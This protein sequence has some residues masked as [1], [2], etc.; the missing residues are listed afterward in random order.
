MK[1]SK[2]FFALILTLAFAFGLTM[3]VFSANADKN[4]PLAHILPDLELIGMNIPTPATLSNGTG[5]DVT[6]EPPSNAA[7]EE[8]TRAMADVSTYAALSSAI[9][10][11]TVATIRVMNDIVMTDCLEIT[12]DIS[13]VSGV[14]GAVTL[15]AASAKRH[16]EIEEQSDVDIVFSN[17]VLDG[18]NAG[19]GMDIVNSYVTISG[20]Y[21]TNCSWTM[22]GAI[23]AMNQHVVVYENNSHEIV[24]SGLVTIN[25]STFENNNSSLGGAIANLGIMRVYNSTLSENYAEESGGAIYA[26]NLSNGSPVVTISNTTIG[27]NE[28]DYYGGGIFALGSTLN[29]SGSEI[30]YNVSSAGGGIYSL[31]CTATITDSNIASNIISST[32]TA[33]T[34][35]ERGGAGIWASGR[36]VLYNTYVESNEANM[37]VG[38]GAGVLMINYTMLGNNNLSYNYSGTEEFIATNCTISFNVNVYQGNEDVNFLGGG[39][40]LIGVT[41]TFDIVNYAISEIAYNNAT[42]GGGIYSTAP[43]TVSGIYINDNEAFDYGGGIYVYYTSLTFLGGEI[44]NNY[45]GI[46]GG[47]VCLD[48]SAFI[49]YDYSLL[50]NIYGN[51]PDNIY[52][53]V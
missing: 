40:A 53:I 29:I 41:S 8:Q 47:G 12:R 25:N 43:V 42:K 20:A 33:P 17:V 6:A 35:E 28:A 36:L 26:L 9:A 49:F 51:T 14:S 16:F 38:C 31:V 18:N 27:E 24:H 50:Q 44:S 13:F 23:L 45:A 1:K 32:N 10:D 46:A 7:R 19:G 34:N 4:D 48:H 3:P 30:L 5:E 2:R 52:S 39:V 22:G 11:P 15:T 21:I 37:P